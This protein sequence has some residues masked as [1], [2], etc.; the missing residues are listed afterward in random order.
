MSIASVARND[1]L[2]VRR[3]L[4]LKVVLAVLI[5]APIGGVLVGI[6][7]GGDP[8]F[9]FLLLSTWLVVGGSIPLVGM[10]AAAPTVAGARESGRLRLLLSTPTDRWEVVGGV[11]C[12]RLLVVVGSLS[13]GLCAGVPYLLAVSPQ[14]AP[15]RL[16][17]FVLFSLLVAATYVSLGLAVS[18]AVGSATCALTGAV[19]LVVG[20]VLWPRVATALRGV[21][22]DLGVAAPATVFEVLGRLTPFGA[23]SQVISD[24]GAI[25][26]VKVT[27]PFLGSGTMAAV[28]LV[29]AT[30]PLVISVRRFTDVDL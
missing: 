21:V 4:L 7:L 18:V 12:S 16:A 14:V 20:T 23:Y 9:R 10:L 11:L 5:A 13:V 1:L 3:S 30:L 8:N 26:G 2:V 19:G 27:T 25:Y 24:P 17:G 22:A 15:G 6:G 28:L 29:W